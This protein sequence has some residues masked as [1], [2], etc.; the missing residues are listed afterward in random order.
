MMLFNMTIANLSRN[1]LLGGSYNKDTI[2]T[3]KRFYPFAGLTG[4]VP[5][6]TIDFMLNNEKYINALFKYAC[7]YDCNSDEAC[8]ETIPEFEGIFDSKISF[9][10]DDN[11]CRL[12]K[13]FESCAANHYYDYQEQSKGVYRY[14]MLDDEL[15]YE[16]SY[17]LIIATPVTYA[18]LYESCF[19]KGDCTEQMYTDGYNVL[20]FYGAPRSQQIAELLVKSTCDTTCVAYPCPGGQGTCVPDHCVTTRDG[21]NFGVAHDHYICAVTKAYF[22]CKGKDD[23]G[24]NVGAIIGAFVAF[25]VFIVIIVVITVCAMRKCKKDKESSTTEEPVEKHEEA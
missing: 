18:G 3:L 2:E 7:E 21:Y 11:I 4:R 13:Q 23:S 9:Y 25:I 12:G 1:F 16:H 10:H 17:D 22:D 8:I 15:A 5:E 20:R 14:A 6:S 19:I 24:I